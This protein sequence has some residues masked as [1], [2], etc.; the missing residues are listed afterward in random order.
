MSVN[1]RRPEREAG[2]AEATVVPR[3][4]RRDDVDEMVRVP[5]GD[6]HRA[7]LVH[8]DHLLQPCERAGA[9]VDLGGSRPA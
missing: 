4:E 7:D 6:Q 5:V 1:A 9:S 8:A 3:V 2:L